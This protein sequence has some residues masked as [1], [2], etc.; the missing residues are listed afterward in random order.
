M[1]T[2]SLCQSL[3]LIGATLLSG[4]AV[5]TADVAVT[6]EESLNGSTTGFSGCTSA[7]RQKIEA[8]AQI[9]R[10]QVAGSSVAAMNL[11]LQNAYFSISHGFYPEEFIR[12]MAENMPT[13]ISCDAGDPGVAAHAPLKISNEEVTFSRWWLDRADVSA[14]K[15]A[16]TFL[17]EVAHNKGADHPDY[18]QSWGDNPPEYNF[19]WPEQVERCST[20][21]SA[22]K[23]AT[24]GGF[25]VADNNGYRRYEQT[26]G[27]LLAP[28]GTFGG[29]PGVLN[30][31]AARFARGIWGRKGTRVDAFGMTCA[32]RSGGGATSGTGTVGGTGGTAYSRDCGA[33][34]LLVGVK[35]RAG[36][37][38]DAVAPICAYAADVQNGSTAYADPLHLEGGPGGV[39]FRRACPAGM[40]VTR[41]YTRAAAG[42]DRLQIECE[43]VTKAAEP[44][45]TTLLP[46]G[47]RSGEVTDETC[48]PFAVMSSIHGSAGSEVDRL[49]GT[50]VPVTVSSTRAVSQVGTNQRAIAIDSRGDSG[51]A[52]AWKQELCGA[53]SALVG[54]KFRAA[55][56]VDQVQGVCAPLNRW[57]TGDASV[58][59]VQAAHG[60]SG[61][62]AVTRMCP[63]RQFV[64]GWRISTLFAN[65]SRRVS[66]VAP[67]CRQF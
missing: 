51:R 25:S 20:E 19:T 27:A 54:V 21:I 45:D 11:C 2:S 5:E 43:A 4:C 36:S 26:G 12:R 7:Q 66:S 10:A 38:I 67:I 44:V 63:V 64:A 58:T 37:G 1:K 34:Q 48:P 3:I 65:G 39:P 55:E 47:S 6:A 29:A 9:A 53:G 41:V 23:F 30:C 49:G 13:A 33:G 52:A 61:G 50:C 24:V 18:D 31:P 46:A 42:V 14:A 40:A 15:V 16:G 28:V 56:R 62:T 8:A 35:G 22:G 17:H 60:G 57:S 59:T 32:D